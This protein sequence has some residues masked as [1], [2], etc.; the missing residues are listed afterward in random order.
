MASTFG[1]TYRPLSDERG[2]VGTKIG[3]QLA[4]KLPGEIPV[5]KSCGGPMRFLPQLVWEP[6][7]YDPY[8]AAVVLMCAQ[9]YGPDE[10]LRC[11]TFDPQ[12]GSTA[13]FLLKEMVAVAPTGPMPAPPRADGTSDLNPVSQPHEVVWTE[14]PEL[15]YRPNADDL[16]ETEESKVVDAE[17]GEFVERFMSTKR[18]GYPVFLQWDDTPVCPVCGGATILGAQFDSCLG[19]PDGD[20]WLSE[21]GGDGVG[22][23]F[24][25]EAR[26]SDRS[27]AFLWQCT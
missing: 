27:G 6:G 13:V 8:V 5:C 16:D 9:P 17:W 25:C 7:M 23:L 12:S 2:F 26:C 20:V 21:F 3:G 4:L 18:F 22:Y 11:S 10:I 24:L 14:W 1:G 19:G 15:S